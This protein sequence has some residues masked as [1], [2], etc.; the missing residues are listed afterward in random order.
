MT[1]GEIRGPLKIAVSGIP[2]GYQ[3][4][5]AD[6]NWLTKSH[7]KQI[8]DIS[9]RIQLVEIPAR[10]ARETEGIEVLLAEGG[11]RTHYPGELDRKDYEAFFTPSLKWVQICSTGF[12][13]NITGDITSGRVTL[14]NARDLHTVPI[15]ESVMAAMLDHVKRLAQR[16]I[17]QRRRAWRRLD[18]DE[19]NGKTV[20]IIG[21]GNIG[22]RVARFC[23]TFEMTV[24]GSKR[25][26]EPVENVDRVFASGALVDH[27]PAADYIV[28][29]APHTPETEGM[30]NED[31]FAVMKP[32]AYLINVG[33]GQ[34]I[35]ESALIAAL[36]ERRIAGAYLDAFHRE[37]LGDDHVLW[38]M[39]NVLIVPHDSHSSPY[40]GDRLVNIFCA[41]LRR[42]VSGQ[43][44][45]NI[46]DAEKGY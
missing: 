26:I 17:D 37:P 24:I 8:R 16:R 5:R 21:L 36:A 35:E 6:G 11:N 29:A 1:A 9:P 32:T 42:Y 46:C 7:R 41:N 25:T 28:I 45:R 4:P 20:L 44:L 33:R 34:V 15:A 2:R 10:Q 38:N 13:S 40:I 30:L 27:L 31:A 18:N 22:K 12:S 23:K 43:R 3:F 14:T 39:D 19:L